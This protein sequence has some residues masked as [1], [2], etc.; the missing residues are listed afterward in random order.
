MSSDSPQQTILK[1]RYELVSQLASGG[2]A[3]VYKGV[4]QKL[5][6]TVAVKILRPSLTV[7]PLFITRFEN[8]AR[9]IANLAHPN[10]VIVHDVDSD[11]P[12]HYIVM[13]LVN[14]SDLKKVIRTHGA[15]PLERVMN[16]SIQIAKGLGFAHRARIVHADV[17]P[18]NLL[19][20]QND[21]VKITDFGIAQA[22]SD[23]QPAQRASVVWGSP[24]YFAPEQAQGEKPTA[25]AD[26]YSI[27]VVMFEMLTGRLP[28]T[29]TSQQD[30]A[31]A[32]IQAPIPDVREF[33]PN[34]PAE[35]ADI[36]KK[37][38][39]KKANDRYSE[40]GQLE[41]VLRN[42]QDR[43]TG[44]TVAPS[45]PPE[46]TPP[47]QQVANPVVPPQPRPN[48]PI[49]PSMPTQ[50]YGVAP[51]LPSSPIRTPRPPADN[52]PQHSRAFTLPPSGGTQRGG[53]YPVTGDSQRLSRSQGMIPQ[54][55]DEEELQFNWDTV[56]IAL[57]VLALMSVLCLVPLY[58][59]ALGAQLGS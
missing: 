3:V 45:H 30:L 1:N 25:A 35:L 4:D 21:I 6:R 48:A 58:L 15:L 20:T 19:L 50:Q 54:H 10:I 5:G 39:S 38:M 26:V 24:H 57:G 34:V 52:V 37:V 47:K 59:V 2:M 12:T 13:E 31:M 32:H 36:V 55:M 40:A 23:T 8:E 56:T 16:L 41:S 22:F 33:N 43:L 7:D 14:G 49:P 11:G 46:F 42:L 28:Y 18:Q 44:H 29:G 51:D 53:A 27:G 9:S 17:K